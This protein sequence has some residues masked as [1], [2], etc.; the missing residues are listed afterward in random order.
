MSPENDGALE[1]V[2]LL[3]YG[4][5]WCTGVFFLSKIDDICLRRKVFLNLITQMLGNKLY[6]I[7]E[8]DPSEKRS[9]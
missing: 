1:K 2:T 3:R 8:T 7:S 6:R 4:H 5:S 9:F